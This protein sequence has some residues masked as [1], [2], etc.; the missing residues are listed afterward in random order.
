[1][2]LTHSPTQPRFPT[3]AVTASWAH[4]IWLDYKS[5]GKQVTHWEGPNLQWVWKTEGCE[6][7]QAK[8]TVSLS[9]P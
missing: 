7:E 1:M 4:A 6:P 9:L 8:S 5:V 2:S 3:A